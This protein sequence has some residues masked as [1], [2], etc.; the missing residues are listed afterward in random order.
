MNSPCDLRF[1][2]DVVLFLYGII[3]AV[4]DLR[5]R[6]LLVPM[7]FKEFLKD[8][9]PSQ[10][11]RNSVRCNSN[12]HTSCVLQ[13]FRCEDLQKHISMYLYNSRDGCLFIHP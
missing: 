10:H 12:V 7:H 2:D 3:M 8:F 9:A 5:V 6:Q 1:G 11:S 4:V 13:V